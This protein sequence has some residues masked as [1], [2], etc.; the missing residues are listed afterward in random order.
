MMWKKISSPS[1]YFKIHKIRCGGWFSQMTNGWINEKYFV[2]SRYIEEYN[3]YHMAV[4]RRDGDIVNW[5]EKQKIKNELFGTDR[6]AVELY[7]PVNE[8]I[9]DNN[10]FHL[11]VYEEGYK[12]PFSLMQ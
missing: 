9:D 8:L 3:V 1:N 12:F 2:C 11:W 5:S 10:V 4:C 6:T 7:P